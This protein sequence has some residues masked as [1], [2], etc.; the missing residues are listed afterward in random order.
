[1]KRPLNNV[2]EHGRCESGFWPNDSQAR[3]IRLVLDLETD[4]QKAYT[5]WR[6]TVDFAAFGQG[7][8]RLVP[9]LQHYLDEAFLSD[10]DKSFIRNTRRLTWWH[11]SA[12]LK[13]LASINHTLRANGISCMPIK[14]MALLIDGSYASAA[15]RP[16]ADIDIFVQPGD[17]SATLQALLADGWKTVGEDLLHD[18]HALISS[19]HALELQRGD[20]E[21][22]DLHWSL[23]HRY[24]TV[25]NTHSAFW[26]RA[27]TIEYAGTEYTVLNPTHALLQ[28]CAHGARWAYYVAPIR[29][30]VD[31]HRIIS[32][33]GAAIDWGELV[34]EA[35][36]LDVVPPVKDTLLY[37]AG[38]LAADV[39][40]TAISAIKQSKASY[41]ARLEAYICSSPYVWN[42]YPQRLVGTWR[43]ARAEHNSLLSTLRN[44]PTYIRTV[45]LVP[46]TLSIREEMAG[47]LRRLLKRLQLQFSGSR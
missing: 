4:R 36:A 41:T 14:G 27:R 23:F 38:E 42:C 32:V 44:A 37:L 45:F 10:D 7:S 46:Q 13:T 18:I 31:A 9:M 16:T 25:C 6:D 21:H 24:G 35:R 43:Y 20:D 39:P 30:L 22:L 2:F 34:A 40:A 26:D 12:R 47:K 33:H 15:D 19:R 5:A 1:M 11:T 3:L 17:L 28:C 8:Q 29:W